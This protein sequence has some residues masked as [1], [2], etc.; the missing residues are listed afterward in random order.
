VCVCVCVCV[1]RVSRQCL[2]RENLYTCETCALEEVAGGFGRVCVCVCVC[3]CDTPVRRL[4]RPCCW[5]SLPEKSF[6]VPYSRRNTCTASPTTPAAIRRAAYVSIR[7]HTSAY[8]S[9]R[10]HTSA[11]VSISQHTSAY[12]SIRQ[13]TSAYV[14]IR[15][16]TSAYVSIRRRAAPSSVPI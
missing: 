15:Q 8:V 10:Q 1:S 7:Q 9:I 13:H 4:S 6:Q 11:Y 14:S 12:V 3:V 16:H 2:F 5:P